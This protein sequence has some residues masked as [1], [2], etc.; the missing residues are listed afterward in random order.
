MKNLT[1]RKNLCAQIVHDLGRQILGGEIQPG[2]AIPN[3]SVLCERMGVSRTVIREAVKSLAA[4]GLIRSRAKLGTTVL[5]SVSWN[6]LDPDVLE[7]QAQTD[8]DGRLLRHLTQFRLGL[9]PAAAAFAA[10]CASDDQLQT[11]RDAFQAME[12]AVEN[13]EA[14]LVADLRFHTSILH[15]T[16]NPFFSPVANVIRAA[17]KSSIRVTNRQ[18]AENRKSIPLHQSVMQAIWDRDS[19][20]ADHAMRTLLGDARARIKKAGGGKRPSTLLPNPQPE[21]SVQSHE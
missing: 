18:S 5:P 4:K 14:F 1:I 16:G 15:A 13:A 19:V 21:S 9:E 8:V 3:E 20:A 11:I 17:L 12:G 7:W 2:Q 10:Q 6:F